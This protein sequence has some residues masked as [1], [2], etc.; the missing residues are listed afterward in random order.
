MRLASRAGFATLLVL[1]SFSSM[2]WAD[3]VSDRQA[4]IFAR[5][6]AYDRNLAERAG[7]KLAIG[8]LYISGNAASEKDRDAMYDAFVKA[9]KVKVAGLDVSVHKLSYQDIATL[10]TQF[11]TNGIDALYVCA[12][13][14]G[15]IASIVGLTQSKSVSTMSSVRSYADKGVSVV[16]SVADDKPKIVVNL[17]ASKSEGMK[18][19]GELLK[20]AEV[21]K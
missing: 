13:L 7:E 14:D 10:E 17:E 12:G 9:S 18:L 5:A 3:D 6:L 15:E 4:L 20:I 19:S 21:I 1:L 11:S 16:V 8:V 2:A